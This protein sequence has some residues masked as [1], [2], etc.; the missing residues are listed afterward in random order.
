MDIGLTDESRKG[1]VAILKRLLADEH[2]LQTKL[3]NFHWNVR[4]PHFIALHKLYEEQ[5]EKLA[6][7]IDEIAER[8]RMLDYLAP[9]TLS[10]FLALTRLKEKPEYY[11]DS[12]TMNTL[13]VEDHEELICYLRTDIETCDDHFKDVGT[14]DFLT[15]LL[16]E[17]EM[18]AWFL[19]AHIQS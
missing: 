9:G 18:M 2:V 5:Y 8:I 13:L 17:H 1:S 3:K 11:P 6:D 4:G 15:G 19:R 10:E 12:H 16:R 14:A 7:L